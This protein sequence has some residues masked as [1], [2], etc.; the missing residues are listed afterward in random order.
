MR[1][2]LVLA[3]AAAPALA[4]A[5]GYA[6][7]NVNPRDLAMSG[8]RVAAQDSAAAVYGNPSSLARLDGLNLSLAGALVDFA[9]SYKD[10]LGAAPSSNTDTNIATPPA[11]F[12][13]WSAALPNQMR[14]GVGVGLSV[15]FGGNVFWPNNWPG[16]FDILTVDRRIY[17][18]YVTAGL[19]PLPWLRV[20]GGFIWYRGT[21]K[22]NQR[23]AGT[24]DTVGTLATAGD[25]FSYDVSLELQPIEPLRLGFD[26]KHKG[27]M[28]LS[29]HAAFTGTD[30]P[31][32]LAPLTLNQTV[33]HQ[34]TAPNTIQAG[35]AFQAT[36][37][38]LVTGSFTWDRF[39]VYKEDAFL[40]GAGAQIIVPRNYH[41]GYTWRLGAELAPIEKLKVRVGGLRDVSPTPPEWLSPTIP[42]SN[43]WAGSL[44]ASYEILRGLTVD[45]AYFHAFFDEVTTPKGAGGTFNVFPATYKPSANIFSLG[46]TW[47]VPFGQRSSIAQ[48]R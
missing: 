46:V 20:G 10:P 15:P 47:A 33:T 48:P 42:D 17:G 16:Q 9:S 29:G 1:K 5:G 26:Y 24:T 3:L 44:G 31:L 25:G 6:V 2:L 45:A 7:P 40:G 43:V 19:E 14:Y 37:Q 38:L 11:V 22:L 35:V 41:N 36:P 27:T 30:V 21:E 28:D 12:A 32:A 8:S 18:T 4:L 23:I 13:S 34:L 39:V